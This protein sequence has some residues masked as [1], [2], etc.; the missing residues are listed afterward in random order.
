MGP[1]C[2]LGIKSPSNQQNTLKI[3]NPN[4]VY[5]FL[6]RGVVVAEPCKSC[7]FDHSEMKWMVVVMG[8]FTGAGLLSAP[9][10]AGLWRSPWLWRIPA[11]H[12]E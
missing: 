9:P 2:Y 1:G 11:Q 7:S 10:E 3:P 12:W 6:L 5:A 4:P 8:H